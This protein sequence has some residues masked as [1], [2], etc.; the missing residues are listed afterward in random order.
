M[1]TG[2]IDSKVLGMNSPYR[3]QLRRRTICAALNATDYLV[4]SYN[5][6]S[7]FITNNFTYGRLTNADSNVTYTDVRSPYYQALLLPT[8]YELKAVSEM[9][10]YDTLCRIMPLFGNP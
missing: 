9:L 3:P 8:G 7:G 6:T 5:S 4:S 2:Y 1:D 10:G